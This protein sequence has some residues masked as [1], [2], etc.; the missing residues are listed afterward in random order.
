MPPDNEPT[1]RA[2]YPRPMQLDLGMI[3]L[4]G[5]PG[6]IVW[7]IGQSLVITGSVRGHQKSPI[8]LRLSLAGI[9]LA[10]FGWFGAVVV[11]SLGVGLWPVALVVLIL[12][13]WQPILFFWLAARPS[14]T[15][16][17]AR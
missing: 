17:E 7:S 16:E 3:L 6:L 13:G 14:V 1:N 11:A 12:V 2:M 10:L 5:V 15:R 9:G 4:C 8:G